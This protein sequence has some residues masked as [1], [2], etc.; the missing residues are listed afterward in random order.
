MVASLG[1]ILGALLTAALLILGVL[2]FLPRGI[3]PLTLNAASL[4]VAFPFGST[5]LV[6]GLLGCMA[7]VSGAAVET[8]LSGAYNLCQFYKLPWGKS[9][10]ARSA[11]VFT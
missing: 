8:S 10:P 2:I 6:L 4:T 9:L 7:C 1:S 3:F 5:A 11:P